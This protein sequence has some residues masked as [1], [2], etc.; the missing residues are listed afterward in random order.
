MNAI[1]SYRPFS[2]GTEFM[3]WISS[4][5]D[6]CTKGPAIGHCGPNE[7]CDIENAFALA[8]IAG[9]TIKDEIIGDEANAQRIAA[10]LGWSGDGEL[11]AKCA[12]FQA[13]EAS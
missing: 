6:R 9:G 11:P 2:N 5:C 1:P 10:R 7:K 4:N 3:D 12:E 13:K 8:S